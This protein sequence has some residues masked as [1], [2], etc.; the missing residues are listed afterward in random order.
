MIAE[1][2]KGSID[3]YTDFTVI[4]NDV[5]PNSPYESLVYEANLNK[6]I[7]TLEE[8]LSEEEFKKFQKVLAVKLKEGLPNYETFPIPYPE[9]DQWRYGEGFFR[10][11]ANDDQ[12][13]PLAYVQDTFT[14]LVSCQVEI[15]G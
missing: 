3:C 15:V 1:Q 12:Y 11:L 14:E 6:Y 5:S 7:K 4:V 10:Q 8:N 2:F 13:A 9:D